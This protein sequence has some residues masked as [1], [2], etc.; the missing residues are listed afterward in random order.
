MKKMIM[1]SALAL[2]AGCATKEMKSTPFYE[3]SDVTYTGRQEDRVNVWPLAYWR[4]PVGSVLWPMVS[5]SD[6][7][8][9]FF[10]FYSHEKDGDLDAS[11]EMLEMKHLGSAKKFSMS[12]RRNWL[13]FRYQ[14]SLRGTAST[15]K[16]EVVYDGKF[17]PWI[18]CNFYFGREVK[19]DAATHDKI[20]D[21]EWKGA[22]GLTFLIY[23]YQF[24]KDRMG[25]NGTQSRHQA[26][27]GFW[28]WRSDNE[29]VS[30]DVFPGFT[31]DSKTN[32]YT[33]A[34]LFWRLFRYENDPVAGKKADLL[35]IPVW[36]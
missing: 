2:L 7:H 18:L 30:L 15:N 22:S 1:V 35:F 31:Y 13:L 9:S 20:A 3:G 21:R 28:D 6:S 34:S 8:F 29:N 4:A 11:M 17:E 26:I 24:S 16:Y 32:G 33:K 12:L 19:F 25:F 10:P 27:I 36:R 23:Q 14:E 5:F